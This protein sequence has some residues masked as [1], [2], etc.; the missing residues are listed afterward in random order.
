MLG[1]LKG[2]EVRSLDA[3]GLPTIEIDARVDHAEGAR[4]RFSNGLT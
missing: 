1:G 4:T 3:T 2:E